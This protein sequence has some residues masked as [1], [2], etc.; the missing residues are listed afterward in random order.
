MVSVLTKYEVVTML[1]YR[2]M[3]LKLDSSVD[4]LI[5][6]TSNEHAINFLN[7]LEVNSKY[8]CKIKWQQD[9]HYKC[10]FAEYPEIK[11]ELSD[12][13]AKIIK[14]NIKIYLFHNPDKRS[15]LF[16]ESF[17]TLADSAE[18]TKRKK[19]PWE[20]IGGE[21]T[22]IS[23]EKI[24]VDLVIEKMRE[25][26]FAINEPGIFAAISHKL[27]VCDQKRCKL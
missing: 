25:N 7:S 13:I 10:F 9:I 1:T 27:G 12:S 24:V 5:T 16:I 19:Q 17:E 21:V 6:K 20:D 4:S 14:N 23:M 15:E 22:R 2:D 26:E 8:L 18:K 11:N 3:I